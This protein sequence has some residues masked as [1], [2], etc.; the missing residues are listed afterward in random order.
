MKKLLLILFAGITLYQTGIAQVII[1]RNCDPKNNYSA[2]RFSEIYNAGNT[3]VDLTGWTLENIQ[4]G[5]VKF[6]WSLSGTINPGKTKICGKVNA[7]GQT[8]TPD[9]TATWS[10]ASWNG[11]GGDGTILKDNNGTVIDNAVQDDATKTFD[12]KEM[13]RKLTVTSS[14]ATYDVSQWVFSTVNDA[15]DVI[16][17]FHGTVWRKTTSHTIWETSGNWDDET[18]TA[19]ADAYIPGGV[20]PHIDNTATSP[21][22]ECKS[23]TIASGGTLTV[24][25][26]NALTVNGDLSID[27][28]VTPG[29]LTVSS[30]SSGNGSLIVNGTVTGSTTVQRDIV[31]YTPGQDDGWHGIGSPVN[32]MTMSG[33]DFA[34]GAND[35]LYAWSE[36]TNTWLNSKVSGNSITNFTNGIGYLV[37]YQTTATKNFTGTLNNSNVSL[38][39]L[40]YNTSQGNGWHLLGNPF[41]SVL[42]WGDANWALTGVGG[43]AK[44]WNETA[45]NYN[46]ISSG[47]IIPSTNGFFVQ[48]TSATN[49]LTIPAAD[50]TH[51]TAN[52]YKSASA[53]NQKET[54][55]F[56]VNDDANGYYD[57]STLGFKANATEGCDISFDS[58]KL[59]SMVKTA[60]SLWTVSKE[61]NFSTN[62]LPEPT[63]AYDIPLD[64]RAGVNTVYHL[65]IEGTNSFESTPLI[66]EDLQTGRKI[67]LSNENS[68]DFTAEKGDDVNRFVLHINGV[69]G[70][71][72]LNET[73]GIQ[74]FAYGK[75]VYLYASG[76]KNLNGKVSVF[77]TLG[78]EI[79]TGSMNGMKSQK[80]SLN[81]NTGI[82]FVRVEENNRVVTR[83]VFIK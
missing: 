43:V 40:S 16:P 15:N 22:A 39:N 7:T 33:S 32:N 45:A 51:N 63:T 82:Y 47:G 54:L 12:N 41:S 60:P 74:V 52:N 59:F 6:S 34:P 19:T 35:D 71:P 18:P 21:I 31:A 13:K 14:T 28:S 9:F 55:K 44:V 4:G 42:T 79:Y 23:L 69:T 10:G 62:Y 1:A 25:A 46:D 50:R 80:I 72:T 38:S 65:T 27:A 11:K 29:T 56:K 67:N 36:A 76:Q 8:I 78:Q 2:D 53:T 58:H 73:D 64:F 17:G 81:Q 75:T 26:G 70:I 77:N 3:A 37:A 48:V 66:L 20:S 49:S 24:P 83:K 61:Q 5:K 30:T 68:Y 57:I